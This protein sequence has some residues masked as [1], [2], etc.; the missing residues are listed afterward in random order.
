MHLGGS[1]GRSDRLPLRVRVPISKVVAVDL[2]H[3]EA[4]EQHDEMRLAA[5]CIH[6]GCMRSS[7]ESASQITWNY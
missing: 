5:V 2:H 1:P 6:P 3:M 4:G 7:V